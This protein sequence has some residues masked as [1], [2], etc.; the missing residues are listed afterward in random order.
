MTT[1]LSRALLTRVLVATVVVSACGQTSRPA[2]VAETSSAE[3]H[4]STE[5]HSRTDTL[6]R[7]DAGAEV[8]VR[9]DN[10][11]D[12]GMD[13]GADQGG[14]G[15]IG[16]DV[17]AETG[18]QPEVEVTDALGAPEVGCGPDGVEQCP[19][20]FVCQAGECIC[21]P[22]C[23]GK[24]CGGDGCGGQCGDC[25]GELGI[26]D[27]GHCFCEADNCTCR[28]CG[29]DGCG[30]TCGG[31]TSDA[32]C[33]AGECFA[34]LT[35]CDDSN[36][37]PWDG[38]TAGV[39]SEAQVNSFVAGAQERPA[40]GVLSNGGYLVAWQSKP[41]AGQGAQ[42]QDGDSC[43]VVARRFGPG[44]SAEAELLVNTETAGCQ[45]QPAVAVLP[46]DSFV[47]VWRGA[48]EAPSFQEGETITV[49][50]IEGQRFESD[51]EKLGDQVTLSMPFMDTSVI[52]PTVAALTA[53]RVI[54]AWVDEPHL[55]YG[56]AGVIYGEAL[57][58]NLETVDHFEIEPSCPDGGLDALPHL[59]RLNE[60]RAVIVW[61][62]LSPGCGMG[63]GAAAFMR[64][65][66]QE[67]GFASGE[68]PLGESGINS[69]GPSAAAAGESGNF[70]ACWH[71]DLPG[72]QTG[73]VVR[74]FGPEGEHLGPVTQASAPGLPAECSIAVLGDGRYVVV[75]R[76][77]GPPQCTSGVLGQLF[78]ADGAKEGGEFPVSSYPL[79]YHL[80]PVVA[81]VANG[82]FVVAWDNTPP[83]IGNKPVLG[84]DG[85]SAGIFTQGFN[86]DGTKWP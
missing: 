51:G 14:D 56:D 18:W 23:A 78:S 74:Q 12:T 32:T 28:E 45:E 30:G 86:S 44:N 35:D 40:L 77:I 29:P 39:L 75:W 63:Y 79:P 76:K 68:L 69:T 65:V 84:Q 60:E 33:V 43:G 58:A 11:T 41:S 66:D 47:V 54:V 37:I 73:I 38:C 22:D 83:T 15:Q 9:S 49:R 55:P 7:T 25:E 2:E 71:S 6:S 5:T 64:L 50:L 19:Q 31:C 52:G 48:I 24:E 72:G 21:S 8:R 17:P 53:D 26:C 20:G 59:T 81:A 80:H 10:G 67:G 85:L 42:A 62:R 70:V 16:N 13:L 57:D 61:T 4:S 1:I 34:L 36:D 27:G 3:T 46:D 82:G